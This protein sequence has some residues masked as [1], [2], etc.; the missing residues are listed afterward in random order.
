MA[1]SK[2]S[3]ITLSLSKSAIANSNKLVAKN[4][5][6]SS[7]GRAVYASL[8]DCAA[9]P[10]RK[11][12]SQLCIASPECV[13]PAMFTITGID[14]VSPVSVT[15]SPVGAQFSSK[16]TLKP[17]LTSKPPVKLLSESNLYSHV[18]VSY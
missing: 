16:L 18:S 1:S 15:K 9:F 3:C 2:Y 4:A 7:A 5:T 17:A 11:P 6:F 13:Q 10:L 8:S 12:Y 14:S